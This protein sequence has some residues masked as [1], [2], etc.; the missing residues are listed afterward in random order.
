[1]VSRFSPEGEEMG[2]A[3]HREGR[4]LRLSQLLRPSLTERP[5]LNWPVPPT[6]HVRNA[7]SWRGWTRLPAGSINNRCWA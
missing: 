3:W 7:K 2:R 4:K 1:M 5:E 6:R